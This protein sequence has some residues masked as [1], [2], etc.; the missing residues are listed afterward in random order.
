MAVNEQGML[1]RDADCMSR[2][3]LQVAVYL[4][5]SIYCSVRPATQCKR[6]IHFY[7]AII[8]V[9]VKEYQLDDQTLEKAGA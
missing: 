2:T 4:L 9:E 1:Y 6:Q 7:N 8:D 5:Q 3:R